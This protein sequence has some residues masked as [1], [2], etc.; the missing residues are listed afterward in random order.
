MLHDK[1][2]KRFPP[3]C[4]PGMQQMKALNNF[5]LQGMRMI[6]SEFEDCGIQALGGDHF[7]SRHEFHHQNGWLHVGVTV[8]KNKNNSYRFNRS[9][10]V[11]TCLGPNKT[12]VPA[13]TWHTADF[14][15][16][17]YSPI[18]DLVISEPSELN[19][20]LNECVLPKI[21]SPRMPIRSVIGSITVPP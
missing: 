8:H 19:E 12:F 6:L 16:V 17:S 10:Q 20:L 9:S 11:E 4:Q 1:G 3:S 7:Q 21:H 15:S 2:K 14:G 13:G 18:K 5:D